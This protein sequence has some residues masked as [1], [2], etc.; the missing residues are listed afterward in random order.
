MEPPEGGHRA[1]ARRVDRAVRH[2]VDDEADRAASPAAHRLEECALAYYNLRMADENLEIADGAGV[3]AAEC[4]STLAFL[5]AANEPEKLAR[6]NVA[7]SVV[8]M[9]AGGMRGAL[10]GMDTQKIQVIKARVSDVEADA[11]ASS[12]RRSRRCAMRAPSAA[13]RRATCAKKYTCFK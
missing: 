6:A 3:L 1:Y 2:V 13:R 9:D 8:G 7:G 12:L 5:R 10:E 11:C 4:R